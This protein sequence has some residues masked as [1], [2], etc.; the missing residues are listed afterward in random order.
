MLQ[1][2]LERV[3][4]L[5][6]AR[7]VRVLPVALRNEQRLLHADISFFFQHAFF[8]SFDSLRLRQGADMF[9]ILIHANVLSQP[10][11]LASRPL[12]SKRPCSSATRS[13]ESSYGGS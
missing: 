7:R 4:P 5:E 13:F 12:S 6:C 2:P 3:R 1:G 10:P 8:Q 9:K 11:I